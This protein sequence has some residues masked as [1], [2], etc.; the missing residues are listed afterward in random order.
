MKQFLVLIGMFLITTGAFAT[1][2]AGNVKDGGTD[3]DGEEKKEKARQTS[4]GQVLLF[5]LSVFNRVDSTATIGTFGS[6]QRFHKIS[7]DMMK[8]QKGL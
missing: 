7:P 3:P 1:N 8:D 5:D 4:Q 6:S 2:V